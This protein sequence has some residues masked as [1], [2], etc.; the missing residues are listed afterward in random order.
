MKCLRLD[1]FAVFSGVVCCKFVSRI[2]VGISTNAFQRSER[3][4]SERF[5]MHWKLTRSRKKF[6]SIKGGKMRRIKKRGQM[7]LSCH[8]Q[9]PSGMSRNAQRRE[10]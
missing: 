5:L 6:E 8:T 1:N 7:F 4:R 9:T 3:H 2:I 10:D